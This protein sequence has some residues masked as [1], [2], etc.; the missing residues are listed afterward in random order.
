MVKWEEKK[1]L[2]KFNL[3]TVHSLLLN[4]NP[5]FVELKQKVEIFNS[6]IA[7]GVHRKHLQYAFTK[8]LYALLRQMVQLPTYEGQLE[9]LNNVYDWT[10]QGTGE[11][12]DWDEFSQLSKS[13]P[14]TATTRTRPFSAY[15]RPKSGV[16]K[17]NFIKL[18]EPLTIRNDIKTKKTVD[19]DKLK[20]GEIEFYTGARTIH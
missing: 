13:R 2:Q 9:M 10:K 15:S 12:G 7:K 3:L 16:S 20:P 14:T 11:G 4:A 18:E 6:T 17:V 5:K 1:T 8:Q 19:Y